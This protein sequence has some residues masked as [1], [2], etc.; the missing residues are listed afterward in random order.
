MHQNRKCGK[1]GAEL[2]AT[3]QYF[4]K[5]RQWLKRTCLRCEPAP[6]LSAR[7]VYHRE[8]MAKHPNKAK[9]YRTRWLMKR[10]DYYVHYRKR[11]AAGV[12]HDNS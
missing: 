8:Y 9:L 10:P 4:G 2:P 1:C 12:Q 5:S 11:R 3:A 6:D 7:A